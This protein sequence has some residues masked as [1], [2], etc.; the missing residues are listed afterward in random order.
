MADVTVAFLD[1]GQ[2]DATVVVDHDAAKALLIDCPRGA[3]AVVIAEIERHGAGLDTA[4]VT[5][6]HLDHFGGVLDTIEALGCRRLLY[7]H[8]TLVA[9]Q[10][11]VVGG[12]TRPDPAVVASLRRILE[13]QDEQ[14]G[15][16]IPGMTDRVGGAGFSFL[17]PTHRDLTRGVVT[18]RANASSGVVVIEVDGV[19]VLIGGDADEHVWLRLLRYGLLPKV[20]AVRWPH[21]GADLDANAPGLTASIL[22]EL[23]ATVVAVSVGARN[24][25]GHP[26]DSF[27]D[28][29]RPSSCTLMCTEATAKC[30]QAA[31][32][33]CAAVIRA[34]IKAGSIA[35]DPA[36]ADHEMR[37]QLL[38]TPRCMRP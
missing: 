32:Q 3:E 4:I 21:H 26:S 14:L 17:A 9:Q 5:H 23:G 12:R 38:P 1:V 37:V 24:T 2:G 22:S 15:P 27:L 36:P 18:H 25:Y 29:V 7:N 35:W 8:D 34:R 13:L 19:A 33:P 31:P 30:A 28:A 6:S 16:A 11:V 10:P 20:I